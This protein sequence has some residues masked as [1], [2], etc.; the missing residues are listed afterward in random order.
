VQQEDIEQRMVSRVMPTGTKGS[1]SMQRTSTYST[2]R[3]R[4]AC[5]GRSPGTITRL[6]RMVP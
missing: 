1:R 5:S 3:S 4:S 6:G 2:P